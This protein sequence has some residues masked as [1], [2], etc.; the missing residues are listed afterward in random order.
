MSFLSGYHLLSPLGV[1][2]KIV[3]VFASPAGLIV[4][5]PPS[6]IISIL[7]ESYDDVLES[8]FF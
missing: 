3:F 8:T 4:T 6:R 5:A 2:L 7:L 1:R